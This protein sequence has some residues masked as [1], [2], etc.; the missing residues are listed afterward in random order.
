MKAGVYARRNICANLQVHRPL[1]HSC[2]PR[3]HK[4]AG[5]LAAS[6]ETTARNA[7][8]DKHLRRRGKTLAKPLEREKF[9]NLPKKVE[10]KQKK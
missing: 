6:V 9:K 8:F 4:A 7:K 10:V 1:E 2:N 5:T 3:L